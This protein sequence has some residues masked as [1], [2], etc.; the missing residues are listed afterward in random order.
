[1]NY[2]AFTLWIFLIVFLGLGAYRLLA[3]TL[4][5][6][7]VNWILLPG[8]IVSQMAYIFGCLITAGEIRR[9]KIVPTS[10]KSSAEGDGEPKTEST[11]KLKIIGPIVAS[12]MTIVACAGGILIANAL[13]GGPVMDEFRRT[14]LVGGAE[15]SKQLPCCRD[16][17]WVQIDR[18]V[19]LLRHT[20]RT[21]ANLIIA[22]P[23]VFYYC[24]FK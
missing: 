6:L 4:G 23:F 11:A 3:R 13:L 1:M 22:A 21:L 15:L 2:A 5:S 24:C 17:V 12:L 8:T 14:A 10:T 19:R 7:W 16:D 9:A 20:C 18:Q